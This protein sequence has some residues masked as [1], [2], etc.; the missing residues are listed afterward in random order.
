MGIVKR[1]NKKY[2]YKPRYYKSDKEGSPYKMSNRFD[3]YRS[4]VGSTGGVKSRFNTAWDDLQD[5]KGRGVNKIILITI[6]VLVLL[7]L[8]IID[9]DLSIFEGSK[10]I[11]ID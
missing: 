8:W 7:F 11:D 2:D 5:S 6:V 10:I 4:T 1:T 9:F 3:A